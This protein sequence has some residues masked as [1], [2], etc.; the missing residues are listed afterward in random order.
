MSAN[1]RMF[2]TKQRFH[3]LRSRSTTVEGIR[4]P[5]LTTTDI[6]DVPYQIEHKYIMAPTERLLSH[7]VTMTYD[8]WW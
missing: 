8:I 6:Y 2:E 4:F 3:Y 7:V 5:R 1:A